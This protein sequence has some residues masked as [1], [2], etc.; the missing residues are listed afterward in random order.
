MARD[1][2]QS[3]GLNICDIDD[4]YASRTAVEYRIDCYL[5]KCDRFVVYER[6]STE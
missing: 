4:E 1:K 2:S 3:W 6:Y 5:S